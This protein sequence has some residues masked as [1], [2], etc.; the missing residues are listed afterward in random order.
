[1]AL[2]SNLFIAPLRLPVVLIIS[3]IYGNRCLS[4]VFVVCT[5][6]SKLNTFNQVTRLIWSDSVVFE[7]VLCRNDCST[8][9][10]CA[11][12]LMRL[13]S[14]KGRPCCALRLSSRSRCRSSSLVGSVPDSLLN[15]SGPDDMSSMIFMRS[16]LLRGR[17]A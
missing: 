15:S 12:C 14:G 5:V 2:A 10:V 17:H 3:S 1:M 4:F 16:S 6:I 11:I 8:A 13:S 7:L 9:S